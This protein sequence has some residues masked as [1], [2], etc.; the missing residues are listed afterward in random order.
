MGLQI[1]DGEGQGVSA[2]VTDGHQL[3]VLAESHELQHH[4]SLFFGRVYQVI[5]D[6]NV[7]GGI[8]TV[9]HMTNNSTNRL[10]ITFLRM[11]G[12]SFTG[13]T[14]LPNSGTFCQFGFGT[15]YTSNGVDVTP[16]NVNRTSNNTANVTAKDDGPVVGGTFIEVDRWY[17]NA[18]AEQFVFDKQGSVILG[19]NDTCEIRSTTDH[20]TGIAYTRMTFMFIE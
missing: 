16:V 3:K 13:G 15:T 17:P 14:V 1:E 18:L 12:V 10:A 6:V 20:L 5:G 7:T 2:G 9:L 4:N 11:Q 19:K 8:Q